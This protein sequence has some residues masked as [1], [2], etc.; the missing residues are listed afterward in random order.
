MPLTYIIDLRQPQ[1]MTYYLTHLYWYGE[2]D[3]QANLATGLVYTIYL[4]LKIRPAP[5]N[6]PID[7]LTS[8]A[9]L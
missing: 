3:P 7:P 6:F 9:Q 2:K 1:F 5:Y 8:T 4:T